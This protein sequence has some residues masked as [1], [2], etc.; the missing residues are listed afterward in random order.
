[1]GVEYYAGISDEKEEYF[2]SKLT[3]LFMKK[4]VKRLF[5]KK[6]T[7]NNK[8]KKSKPTLR[9]LLSSKFIA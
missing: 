1:M 9:K 3:N 5:N 8:R 6:N 2:Y 4:Q 7:T